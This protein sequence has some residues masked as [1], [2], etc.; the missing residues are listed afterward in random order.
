MEIGEIIKKLLEDKDILEIHIVKPGF[1][2]I[3]FK[4]LIWN[5]L[6][7]NIIEKPGQYGVNNNSIKKIIS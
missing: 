1:L 6:L 4:P 7:K 5:S 2:N 3:T